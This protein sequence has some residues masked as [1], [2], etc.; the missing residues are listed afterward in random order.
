MTRLHVEVTGSGPAL[1]LVPGGGGDAG[2]FAGVVPLLA[3]R[4]TVITYDRRGN[5]RSP[6]PSADA[7]VDAPAQ[8]ADAVEVLDGAGVEQA[9]VF[10]NSGGAIIALELIA[11]HPERV[12]AAVVHEPPLVTVLE[13]GAPERAELE[14]IYRT[15]LRHGSMRAFA[16][17]GAMTQDDPPAFFR[18][19][20]GQAVVAAGSRAAL[21]VGGLWRHLTGRTPGTMT[22]M[23]T[24]ADILVRREMLDLC[25]EFEA[26]R[27]ALA[28]ADVPWVLATG[29][30]SVGK[31]YH[32]PARVLG[33]AI[34]VP[35]VE[36]P[37]G[38]T[39]Y[40][41]TPEEFVDALLAQYGE[42][43]SWRAQG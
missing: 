8:V 30:A 40:Q 35:C 1:L 17:F 34:G 7:P 41:D 32:R 43:E 16:A 18:S 26:D 2:M 27:D 39:V 3:D 23:L 25:L 4:F 9:R 11:R 33:E 20:A 13:P 24:N 28:S 37:G 36:F 29:A 15:G 12:A 6:L 19:A 10:G 14:A 21:A 5:S 31:P 38:H 42:L 22:R